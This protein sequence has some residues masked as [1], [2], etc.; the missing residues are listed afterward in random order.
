MDAATPIYRTLFTLVTC[1]TG[2]ALFDGCT[3]LRNEVDPSQLGLAAPK[4]VVSGFLSPQDTVIAVKVT[5]SATVVGDS[6]SLMQTGNDITNATVTIAE[7]D[8]TVNLL[9]NN[10]PASSTSAQ[11]Y[12]SASARLLPIVVGRT[13]TLTVVTSNGQKASSSCTIPA[14]V[15]PK[16]IT[17]DSI[18][19]TQNRVK[20]RRYFVRAQW[21]DPPDQANYY[22]V[23]GIFRLYDKC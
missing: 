8:R 15:S 5:R 21:Q 13:Y 3:S 4:L 16:A 7:G 2:F 6:L 23:A 20:V 10:R 19:D 12:Y 22:Q 17:F 9:Y 18:D 14:L 1:L 11:P